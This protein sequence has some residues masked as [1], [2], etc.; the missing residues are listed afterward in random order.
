MTAILNKRYRANSS[1]ILKNESDRYGPNFMKYKDWYVRTIWQEERHGVMLHCNSGDVYKMLDNETN[2][3][4][5]ITEKKEEQ[6]HEI[7]KI[8]RSN[9]CIFKP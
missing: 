7:R 9:S 4:R 2:R 6:I 5:Y 8:L 1:K 3:A